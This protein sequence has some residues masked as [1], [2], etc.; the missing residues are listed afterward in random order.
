MWALPDILLNRRDGLPV[1]YVFPASGTPVIE[2]AVAVVRGARHRDAAR[3][4]VEY[5]G[6]VE[7]QLLATREAYRLPARL[8]LPADSLPAW[9]RD[10][11]RSMKVADV[12]WDL[13]AERGAEWMRYWDEHVRGKGDD[14]VRA[15]RRRGEA[16]R[17]RGGGGRGHARGRA[18]RGARAAGAERQRQDGAAAAAGG[19]C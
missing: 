19:P 10:V 7:A 1:G 14:A 18:R 11:R 13:L 16:I 3:A 12:D 2:D 4:F 15:A 5:V 9:A 8:D 6:S 17:Y